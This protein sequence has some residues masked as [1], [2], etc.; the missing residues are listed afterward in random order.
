MPDLSTLIV[1]HVTHDRY[2]DHLRAG[3]CAFYGGLTHRALGSRVEL[4][5]VVG[6]DFCCDH[7]LRRPGLELD[8]PPRRGGATTLFRNVYPPGE[9]RVQTLEAVAGPVRPADVSPRRRDVVHLAPVLHEVD[10]NAWLDRVAARWV[11]INVQGWTRAV[12]PRA[13]GPAR[14]GTRPWQVSMETLRRVDVACLSEEDLVGQGDLLARLRAAVG[15][16]VL[17]DGERGCTVY[18]GERCARVGIC[19]AA[20]VDPTGAGDVFAAAFLHALA[21]GEAWLNA[22]QLAS[23]AASVV[24]EAQGASAI[25]RLP[26]L[27]LP[28]R[29]RLRAI[30]EPQAWPLAAT[31]G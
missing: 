28:R 4:A 15:I 5:S 27:V 14:V 22:A 30:A 24:I 23:A 1:G 18:V 3:G 25:S 7:E 6:E 19:R 17:T 11:G 9:H 16:V 29:D 26:E 13:S 8:L 21:R 2:A 10:L 12:V 31:A 20:P